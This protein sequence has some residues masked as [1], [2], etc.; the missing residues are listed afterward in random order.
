MTYW[1]VAATQRP[2]FPKKGAQL[3]PLSL[4][5]PDAEYALEL[6]GNT[7]NIFDGYF[8]GGSSNYHSCGDAKEA[9]TP[10]GQIYAGGEITTT[11]RQFQFDGGLNFDLRKDDGVV[12]RS[13]VCRHSARSKQHSSVAA[14]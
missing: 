10:M 5:S 1:K 13:A 3:L 9:R 6:V 11:K 14:S 2:N 8:L 7:N 4:I 12:R